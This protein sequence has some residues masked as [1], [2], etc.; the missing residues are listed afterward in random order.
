MASRSRRVIRASSAW[1]ITPPETEGAG[2]AG[3]QCAR[4]LACK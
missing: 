1:N 2:N 3:L 4:S